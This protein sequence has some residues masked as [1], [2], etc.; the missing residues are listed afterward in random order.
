MFHL[1]SK[2][3]M[4][5]SS[6]GKI[7]L[8]KRLN[9]KQ[10]RMLRISLLS[11]LMW[12]RPSSLL[13]FLSWGSVQSSIRPFAEF[14]NVSLTIRQR[15]CFTCPFFIII[16]IFTLFRY[17]WVWWELLYWKNC[18]S[19]N[20]GCSFIFFNISIH[21]RWKEECPMS[22]SLRYW[23]GSV[24]QDDKGC[25]TSSWVLQACTYSLHLLPCSTRSQ[26]KNVC[27]WSKLFNI[28]LRYTWTNQGEN[29]LFDSIK[30]ALFVRIRS[31]SMHLAGDVQVWLSTRKREVT[32]MWTSPTSI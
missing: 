28:P 27:K 24:L 16:I 11:D 9:I 31:T 1:W 19:C 14:R 3:L 17:I 26:D 4:M 20:P 18:I 29:T 7:S 21:F 32:A 23:S 6:C 12:R 10:L 5:K 30:H 22:D 13:I 2:W 25:C 15:V 8:W